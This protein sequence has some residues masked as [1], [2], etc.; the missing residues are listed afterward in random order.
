MMCCT[1]NYLTIQS[2]IKGVVL[3]FNQRIKVFA[4]S[5]Q[6]QLF[7]KPQYEKG[8]MLRKTCDEVTGEIIERESSGKEIWENPFTGEL[9]AVKDWDK[10]EKSENDSYRRTLNTVYDLAR[11]NHWEWFFTFTFN[12]AKVDSFDYDLTSK[13]LSVW[14][15]HLRSRKHPD[16]KY[17]VVPE[18]H[19]SGRWH[20]HG[21]FSGI[22]EAALTDSGH[23]DK[24]GRVIYNFDNYNLGFSTVTKIDGVAEAC[25]YLCK[26]ITKDLCKMTFN[27]KRYWRSRNVDEPVV[28][29]CENVGD[30][31]EKLKNAQNGISP[32][33]MKTV[34]NEFNTIYYLEFDKEEYLRNL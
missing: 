19:K 13:K 12:P 29:D 27:K 32:T 25:S 1:F 15:N 20:F 16:M 10:A 28:V 2:E 26:Y 6:V 4:D 17:L 8:E 21:L 33:Y 24:K 31:L 22:P 5:V 3:C 14:L 18:Q 9:E 7:K 11:A 34:K 23:K 30:F